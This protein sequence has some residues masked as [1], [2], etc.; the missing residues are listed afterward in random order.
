MQP[1][2]PITERNPDMALSI[3]SVFAPLRAPTRTGGLRRMLDIW[4]E[5]RALARLDDAALR[6]IGISGSAAHAEA[7][8]PLWDLPAERR[9]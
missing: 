5:R 2:E 6:D 3:D 7:R 1:T 4:Q 9:C 8:R